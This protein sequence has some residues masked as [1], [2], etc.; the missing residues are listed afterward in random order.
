LI[1][2]HNVNGDVQADSANTGWVQNGIPLAIALPAIT[3]TAAKGHTL[4]TS[5]GAWRGTATITFVKVQW[6]RCSSSGASCV[7]ISGATHN[8]YIATTADQGHRL[9][10]RVYMANSIGTANALSKATAVV[11]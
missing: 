7:A 11:S 10:T 1:V 2:G 6:V 8:F 3:G 4:T 9:R 5:H